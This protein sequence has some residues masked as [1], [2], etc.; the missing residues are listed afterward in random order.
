MTAWSSSGWPKA[1]R[2]MPLRARRRL[3]KATR[4]RRRTE[5][6]RVTAA[7]G[8]PVPPEP[9]HVRPRPQPKPLQLGAAAQL[10]GGPDEL[11]HMRRQLVEAVQVV[12]VGQAAV[13]A[14]AEALGGLGR[15]YT[16]QA[17][18]GWS[19]W[20]SWRSTAKTSRAT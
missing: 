7:L 1:S 13:E 10:P 17:A 16:F 3:A 5:G 6:S 8:R 11:G 2:G 12:G 14:G 20:A 9:E 15:S 19:C 18:V 4:A